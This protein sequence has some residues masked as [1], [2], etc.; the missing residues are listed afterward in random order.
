MRSLDGFTGVRSRGPDTGL[1]PHDAALSATQ[2]DGYQRCPR[3]Y[4]LERRLGVGQGE[5]NHLV[6]GRL[7][8]SVIEAASREAMDDGQAHPSRELVLEQLAIQFDGVDFGG[9]PY[10]AAW[11]RRAIVTLEAYLDKRPENGRV[12][13]VEHEFELEMPDRTWR[14]LVDAVIDL[15]DGRTQIVDYKTGSSVATKAEAAESIQL[16]LYLLAA[17]HDPVLSAIG[18]P[19]AADYWYLYDA[20]TR[21][22]LTT[23]SFDLANVA[24]IIE[25]LEQIAAGIAADDWRPAPGEHCVRCPVRRACPAMPEGAEGFVA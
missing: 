1:V 19:V 14:G 18:T 5:T 9:P 20:V 16:G 8:H 10:D 21:R 12:A 7:I 2:A 24:A 15:G 25:R 17:A 11:L 3:R 4:V 13:A 22:S 6:F 23:R